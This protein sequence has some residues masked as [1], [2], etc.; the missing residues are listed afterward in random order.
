MIPHLASTLLL[1]LCLSALSIASCAASSFLNPFPTTE[2]NT[3]KE[4]TG[5]LT[6]L[7]DLN[8]KRDL[9]TEK[10][11]LI[12]F[13]KKN[14]FPEEKKIQDI[15]QDF[16]K[17]YEK[18]NNWQSINIPTKTDLNTPDEASEIQKM[19]TIE[20][21]L[22]NEISQDISLFTEK[23][24]I[25]FQ[26]SPITGQNILQTWK[27]LDQ[28]RS[29]IIND[30]EISLKK[31]KS[32]QKQLLIE[33]ERE[34]EE[35]R[36]EIKKL[37]T[38]FK[39]QLYELFKSAAIFL[40]LIFGLF[41]MRKISE[42][43]IQKFSIHLSEHRIDVL[44]ALNKW[45]FNILII[46][47]ILIFFSS[48]FI[49]ILPFVAILGTALGFALRD[50]IVSFIGWF[51]IGIKDGYKAGDVIK[52]GN[53]Y[54]RVKEI[55]PLLTIIQEQGLNGITGKR[56]SVPNKRVFEEPV[57]NWSKM[58]NLTYIAIE[59]FLEQD[60][61][62]QKAEKLLRQAI[63]EENQESFELAEKHSGYLKKYCRID[64]E[65]I[66]PKVFLQMDPRGV[67]MRGKI[68]VDMRIRHKVRTKIIENFLGKIRKMKDV[69]LRFVSYG[70][71]D[72]E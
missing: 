55:T 2:T 45:T 59:F 23:H 26:L 3:Q 51:V 58:K 63:T 30:L 25:H 71:A 7:N 64:E 60:S 38:V 18:I 33:A 21:R 57:W 32:I 69:K 39:N 17:L 14:A 47:T 22:I 65:K 35:L 49:S 11:A 53:I 43:T 72:G 4:K 13:E 10:E 40:G 24:Q 68:L 6:T 46:I 66:N 19:V 41:I 62:I 42:K 44:Y 12:E 48:Q 70:A 67:M 56:L 20:Q 5:P 9:L 61:D 8:G 37:Q 54:G 36:P 15:N 1:T 52:I 31:K 29:K 16:A 34:I 50:V 27:Q 28:T